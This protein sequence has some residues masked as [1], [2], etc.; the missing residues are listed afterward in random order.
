MDEQTE[1][2]EGRTGV[3]AD[4]LVGLGFVV[5]IFV[6]VIVGYWLYPISDG[7]RTDHTAVPG[8]TLDAD[9]V[10]VLAGP[11]TERHDPAGESMVCSMVSMTNDSDHPHRN[12]TRDWSVRAPGGITETFSFST[13]EV[14]GLSTTVLSPGAGIV[15]D[16]CF[17][18][19]SG[20]GEYTVY[21]APDG[22]DGDRYA[23]TGHR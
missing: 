11:L 16:V 12:D 9:G 23:W 3:D 17:Y 6:A 14:P 19:T 18:S 4:L 22:P 7:E 5:A 20:P 2:R 21:Y 1:H 13:A 15:G 10:A 8:Q